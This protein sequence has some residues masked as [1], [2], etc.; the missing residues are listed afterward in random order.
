MYKETDAAMPFAPYF[1]PSSTAYHGKIPAEDVSNRNLWYQL[2]E[3]T[4][5]IEGGKNG[6]SKDTA[7]K[8]DGKSHVSEN[9]QQYVDYTSDRDLLGNPRFIGSNVDNGCFE[10]WSTGAMT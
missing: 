1:R 10:T 5:N 2:H 6:T 4:T 8:Y 7:D 3:R 9:L